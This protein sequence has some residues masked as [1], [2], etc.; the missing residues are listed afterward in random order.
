MIQKVS[1]ELKD[2]V[3]FYSMKMSILEKRIEDVHLGNYRL[4]KS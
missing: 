2:Y 1:S 3:L 4:S